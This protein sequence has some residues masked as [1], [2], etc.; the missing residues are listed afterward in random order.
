MRFKSHRRRRYDRD[1]HQASLC[2]LTL[3]PCASSDTIFYVC[4]CWLA[5]C[6]GCVFGVFIVHGGNIMVVL[7]ALP[8]ELITIGGATLGAFLANNQMKVVKATIAGLGRC[9]KGSKYTKARYM[10][11]LAC[12][13]TFCKKPAK[14]A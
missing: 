3:R 1:K 7:Q 13:M 14:R 9:F 11:L 2:Q 4:H 5:G 10:D 12:Y 6:L 8:F